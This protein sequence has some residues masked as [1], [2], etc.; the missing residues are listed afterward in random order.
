M[1]A[2]LYMQLNEIGLLKEM[3]TCLIIAVCVFFLELPK[4]VPRQS[5]LPADSLFESQPKADLFNASP[6][7]TKT[8]HYVPPPYQQGSLCLRTGLVIAFRG[9]RTKLAYLR[10]I[11]NLT[12]GTCC[13]EASKV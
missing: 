9:Y 12:E 13:K 3:S 10:L 11:F 5:A 1:I 4:P 2:F 7:S 6:V 8:F